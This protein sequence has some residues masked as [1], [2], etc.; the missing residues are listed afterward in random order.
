MMDV[1][2]DCGN[3]GPD[4]SAIRG[5]IQREFGAQVVQT[6]GA[7]DTLERLAVGPVKLVLVN[8]KLDRDYSDGM[9]VIRQI[10]SDE[11]W[12]DIPVMLVTNYV[13][14][15]QAAIQ[16]GAMQGF[17]KLSLSDPQTTELLKSVLG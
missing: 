1:V 3:C 4:H 10:R 16:L 12:Q 5:K 11:R 15:Q 7:E 6:H 2:I 13:E 8:R 14:H 9:D 17:G